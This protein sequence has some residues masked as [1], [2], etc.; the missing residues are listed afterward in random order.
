MEKEK[1]NVTNSCVLHFVDESEN[2]LSS[3]FG[4]C[5]MAAWM[6]CRH[7][8]FLAGCS[9]ALIISA[10]GKRNRRKISFRI[11][12]KSV[13]FF[14]FHRYTYTDKN[15]L[16]WGAAFEVASCVARM[17]MFEFACDFKRKTPTRS[18]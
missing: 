11:C 12:I 8:E 9:L 5:A 17:G 1:K 18:S 3:R 10:K 16:A 15:W 2:F 7:G 4:L 14:I 13:F 6:L